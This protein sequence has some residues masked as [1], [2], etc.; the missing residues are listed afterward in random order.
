MAKV[1]ID[2]GDIERRLKEA[3]VAGGESEE[4]AER[5]LPLILADMESGELSEADFASGLNRFRR[6]GGRAEGSC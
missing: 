2:R 5:F 4:S 1:K 6:T 3:L